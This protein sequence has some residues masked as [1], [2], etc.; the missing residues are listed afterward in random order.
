MAPLIFLF[1]NHYPRYLLI[2]ISNEQAR[3]TAIRSADRNLGLLNTQQDSF[4]KILSEEHV[5]THIIYRPS[6]LL[7]ITHHS[8]F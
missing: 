2:L 4:T 1:E 7:A 8:Y 5:K 3:K 6:I